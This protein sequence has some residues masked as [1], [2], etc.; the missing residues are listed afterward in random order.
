MKEIRWS[1]R[2]VS[3]EL[4]GKTDCPCGGAS[5]NRLYITV[6][7]HTRLSNVR[8]NLLDT[9]IECA[10]G[11]KMQE[12]CSIMAMVPKQFSNIIQEVNT[13]IVKFSIAWNTK[14]DMRWSLMC[15]ENVIIICNCIA[16][17]TDAIDSKEILEEDLNVL[18]RYLG[19]YL[20]INECRLMIVYNRENYLKVKMCLEQW[21]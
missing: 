10:C 4:N 13:K 7:C 11:H 3:K 12:P 9:L 16:F 20:E 8:K 19:R 18:E 5:P 17:L 1:T 2:L 6:V 21:K 14:P 15:Y